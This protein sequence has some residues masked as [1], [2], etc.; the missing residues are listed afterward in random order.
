MTRHNEQPMDT[1][2]R[3]FA[4]WATDRPGQSALRQSLR[5]SH[6]RWLRDPGDHPVTVRLGGP[7]LDDHGAMN[8]TLLVVE[9]ESLQVV[10]RFFADDPYCRHGLFSKVQIRAWQWGLGLAAAEVSHPEL[11]EKSTHD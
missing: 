3:Y 11:M 1:Q 6:R 5:P 7:T 8:G 10:D 2:T 9:A 4:I